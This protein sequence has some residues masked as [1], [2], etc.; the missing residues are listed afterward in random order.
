MAERLARAS[1]R[2]APTEADAVLQA[3]DYV[4]QLYRSLHDQ[5]LLASR[6]Y[7]ALVRF[8]RERAADFD[9]PR[10]LRPKNAYNLVRLIGT[11]IGWLRDGRA[12]ARGAR[13]SARPAARH[14]AGASVAR[15]D[16][17][18]GRGAG[19]HLEAARRATKLPARPDAARADAL[20][21]RIGAEAARRAIADEPGPFG[22][23]A[24]A[25]PE[26]A[27]DEEETT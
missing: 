13:R 6:D 14:Q 26:L 8:A 17:A 5:G 9:L 12:G 7:P 18:R 4:K 25:R 24:P 10:D 22:R 3:K 23:D 16:A 19:R 27:L 11:A 20:L 21:C 15:R 1:P 2:A